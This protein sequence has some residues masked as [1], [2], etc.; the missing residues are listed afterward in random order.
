V[1]LWYGFE[2]FPPQAFRL[3][4][5]QLLLEHRINPMSLYSS[6]MWPPRE[7]IPW[8]VEHGLNALNIRYVGTDGQGVTDYVRQE[9]E[10]LRGHGWL[11]LAYVYGFDEVRPDEYD[12]LKTAF[13]AVR[14]AVP[15][16]RRACTVAP[17]EALE[18]TVDIWVPLTA[19]FDPRAAEKRRKAGDEVWWYICAGPWHP[20]CNWFIDYPATDARVLF[21]QT[22]K[23]GVTGFLYYEI[24]MWRTNLITQP[25][26]D[27][28][29]IPPEEEE[30]R[31]AI[32]QGKRW[33]DIPW[34]TFTFSHYNG[35]G[36][37]IY[38][39]KQQTP[40][41]SVR[42]E[43]IR[44]GIEDYDLLSVLRDARAAIMKSHQTEGKQE[45][46]AIATELLGIRPHIA[47][48]LTHYTTTPLDILREREAVARTIL[49]L[50]QAMAPS[51]ETP[52]SA[53][54]G[55]Q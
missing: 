39:G 7:D 26:A 51:Q 2:G 35:D 1:C 28:T 50:R 21:W 42:L 48:D 13:S 18:G 49:R 20:Y 11:P 46:V 23:Y 41:P 14:K 22:F 30:V 44:D 17:N 6:E 36:L 9:A 10:W 45:L 4:L 19:S 47:R 25:S 38:P 12:E 55:G 52:A 24:A 32:E 53:R 37:L 54:P 27:G 31:R 33:P 16:L 43:V 3:K 34:N 40:L 29:Q 5:Y 15:E 8:C